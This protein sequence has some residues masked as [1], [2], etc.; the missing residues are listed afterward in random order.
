MLTISETSG[1]E[2]IGWNNYIWVADDAQLIFDN[3]V[4]K[5]EIIKL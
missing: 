4:V 2:G 1:T 3:Y 5:V